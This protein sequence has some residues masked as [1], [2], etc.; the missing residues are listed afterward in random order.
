MEEW[1]WKGEDLGASWTRQP[2]R[3]SLRA[4]ADEW[5]NTMVE[6]A[7]DM[8]DAAMEAYLEGTEP[9]VDTLRSLIR[10][11]CLAMKFV[12]V[13]CGSAFKNKGVQPMLNCVIDFL[14]SPLDVPRLHGLQARATRPRRGTSRARPTTRS[15]SRRWPSRS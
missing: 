8:D 3:E 11:G 1:T 15:R 5:R 10:K 2:I 6:L 13:T 12:P 9:D 4:E 14:P 7:V